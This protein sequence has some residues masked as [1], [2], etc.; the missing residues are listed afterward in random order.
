MSH[1]STTA[2]QTFRLSLLQVGSSLTHVEAGV[3]TDGYQ[4][5]REDALEGE[6]NESNIKKHLA[7]DPFLVVFQPGD[8]D[9]PKVCISFPV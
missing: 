9:N 7:H 1:L 5:P 6:V 4:T 3:Q 2:P 8:P